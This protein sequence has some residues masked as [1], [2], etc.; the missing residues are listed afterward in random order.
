VLKKLKRGQTPPHEIGKKRP[1]EERQRV[2]K[3]EEYRGSSARSID[4]GKQ[5]VRNNNKYLGVDVGGKEK[6]VTRFL[7]RLSY[8]PHLK[9]SKTEGGKVGGRDRQPC[10]NDTR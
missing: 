7:E 1:E 8:V 3:R 4:S 5:I 6:T 10:R 2:E 9:R